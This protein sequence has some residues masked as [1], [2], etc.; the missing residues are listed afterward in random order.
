MNNTNTLN[1]MS[2]FSRRKLFSIFRISEARSQG[3]NNDYGSGTV[4]VR[5]GQVKMRRS[6]VES[7]SQAKI[8]SQMEQKRLQIKAKIMPV[9]DNN[10][11]RQPKQIKIIE[12]VSG[13]S[14][15]K[16]VLKKDGE[17]ERSRNVKVHPRKDPNKVGH[18]SQKY[19]FYMVTRL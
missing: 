2:T 11:P 13:A 17:K 1:G 12:G 10:T 16:K 6:S 18:V 4:E 3:N 19:L 15:S 8:V 9:A 14:K 5:F 7:P